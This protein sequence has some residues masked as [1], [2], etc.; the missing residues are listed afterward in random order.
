MSVLGATWVQAAAHTVSVVPFLDRRSSLEC[1][2]LNQLSHG[3]PW[4]SMSV[5]L[6]DPHSRLTD[7]WLSNRSTTVQPGAEDLADIH[8]HQDIHLAP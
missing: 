8:L 2:D 4:S 7:V 6:H 5:E 3:R 1:I